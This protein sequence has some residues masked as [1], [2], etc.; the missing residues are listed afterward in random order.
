MIKKLLIFSVF[1]AAIFLVPAHLLAETEEV[2][3]DPATIE[4]IDWRFIWNEFIFTVEALIAAGFTA[5]SIL[6]VWLKKKLKSGTPLIFAFNIL[7]G[8]IAKVF[9]STDEDAK[10]T[11]AAIIDTAF[12]M[13]ET[14]P[15]L[16]HL[17]DRIT[18]KKENLLDKISEWQYEI[19]E[20]EAKIENGHLSKVMTEKALA[21]K[22]GLLKNIE[23][24]EIELIKYDSVDK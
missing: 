24:A 7:A 23:R 18:N 10:K 15:A 9:T 11:Q 20:I 5:L 3:G 16:K 22:N 8:F 17:V 1:V 13:V 12:K 4:S 19:F 21:A 14:V 2:V 6:F